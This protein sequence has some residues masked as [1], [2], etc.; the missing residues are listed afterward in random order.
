MNLKFNKSFRFFPILITIAIYMV[1][2]LA[3]NLIHIN[4]SN[5]LIDDEVLIDWIEIDS[6]IIEKKVL[7]IIAKKTKPIIPKQKKIKTTNKVQDIFTETEIFNLINDSTLT[8]ESD[9]IKNKSNWLDSMVVANPNLSL[10]KYAANE[11]LKQ[12]PLIKSDSTKIAEG[13][14]SF[15]QDYYKSKYPTPVYKIG[16]KPQ[17]LPIDNIISIFRSNDVDEEE[18]KKYLKIG[19]YK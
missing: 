18:I 2:L 12:N 10:L 17:G 16:N 13:I 3:L 7:P 6:K 11:Y 1:I 8:Q 4:Y 5:S 15:M 14:R 9:S 19:K